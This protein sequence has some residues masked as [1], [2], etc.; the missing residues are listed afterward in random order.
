MSPPELHVEVAGEGRP[1]VLLH[2][3]T[4]TNRYV[5]MGSRSLERSG[6]RVVAYD[7]R[8][9]GSSMPADAYTYDAL[10]ADLGRVM[11]EAGMDRAVLAGASMGAHTILRFALDA[12]ERVA[13]LVLV[14][15]A[16]HEDAD[17][18][19]ARWRALA[20]GLR[21]GG[22]D[23]FL[24]AYGTDSLPDDWRETLVT[25]IRQRL[26]LHDHPG[27]VAEAMEQL[28]LSR[29]FRSVDELAALSGVPVSIV[30]D[31]DEADPGHPL[32]VGE[33]YATVIEGSRLIVEEP[34]K[35]PVAWQGGQLSKIIA[36]P[37]KR[38]LVSRPPA[39]AAP[40]WRRSSGCATGCAS[41]ASR[42]PRL[43][44]LLG[45]LPDGVAVAR[46]RRRGPRR[47]V[48]H[49]PRR[50]RAPRRRACARRSRPD[51]MALDRLAEAGLGRGDRHHRGRRPRR[52][53]AHRASST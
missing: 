10:A 51:G 43:G 6:H 29:P 3:L 24:A 7:A 45:E 32:W 31:R 33:A 25:V 1:V 53:A 30:A 36:A 18:D 44:V 37:P 23:G 27:A 41:P 34:G 50:A 22:A 19:M 13:A 9:H 12:P 39:T 5:V 16:Y 15:P 26:S 28:P 49:P 38:R 4:A 40:R 17:P 21:S 20:D 2:G 35:S 11:D 8:G 14:T 48:R 46:R 52:R 42:A 47:A